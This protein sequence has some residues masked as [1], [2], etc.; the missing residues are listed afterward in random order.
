MI[1]VRD[2]C[3]YLVYMCPRCKEVVLNKYIIYILGEIFDKL[4]AVKS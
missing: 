4:I 2:T 1:N 3:K